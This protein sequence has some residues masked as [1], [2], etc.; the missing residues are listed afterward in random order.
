MGPWIDRHVDG[1]RTAAAE[2]L[3][4]PVA[5]VDSVVDELDDLLALD[6]VDWPLAA[7]AAG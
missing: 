5:L 3:I 6:D 7:P 4:A 2:D 1:L